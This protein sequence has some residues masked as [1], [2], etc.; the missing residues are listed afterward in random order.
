MTEIDTFI[1][2]CAN[3]IISHLS[4]YWGAIMSILGPS[5][6]LATPA[7]T[8]ACTDMHTLFSS[9]TDMLCLVWIPWLIGDS[10][11]RGQLAAPY[12]FRK[13][14]PKRLSFR[15]G[16]LGSTTKAFLGVLPSVSPY[17][18]AMKESVVGSGPILM[19]GKSCSSKYLEKKRKQ[20][21][22]TNKKSESCLGLSNSDTIVKNLGGSEIQ[23]HPLLYTSLKPT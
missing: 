17:I 11:T 9:R 6:C 7:S 13:A 16:F 3:H 10:L 20:H 23:G 18:T 15:N 21:D 12:L 8:R 4:S 14:F 19:P 1:Y 22:V 5:L 2:F